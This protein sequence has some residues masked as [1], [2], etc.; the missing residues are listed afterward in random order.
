MLQNM[1]Y[2]TITREQFLFHEMRTTARL[3]Q[4]GKS[5]KE[6]I[7]E[8]FDNNLFQF[9][10]EKMVG[11]IASVCIR[12]LHALDSPEAIDIIAEGSRTTAKQTCFYAIILYYH[13]IWDFMLTVI[14]EKYRTKDFHYSRRDLNSFFT[15]LQEQN[16]EVA[17][18]SEE[19][20]KK[21]KSALNRMLIETEFLDSARSEQLNPVLLEPELKEIMKEK[22]DFACM[23]AFNCFEGE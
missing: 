6:I 12:R 5:D 2:R 9:P 13:L 15:R 8:I 22:K 20:I 21:C 11:N 17:S 7:Q 3:M 14:A 4:A 18:W 10:T 19:T 16:D 1:P 23:A